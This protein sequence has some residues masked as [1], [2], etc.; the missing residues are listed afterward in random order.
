MSN[1]SKSLGKNPFLI[2]QSD[3]NSVTDTNLIGTDN[4]KKIF[5]TTRFSFS[6]VLLNYIEPEIING[7]EKTV[8]YSEINT[9]LEKGDKVFILNGNYDSD[10]YIDQNKYESN[11]DG[12]EVLDVDRCRIVLDIKYNGN[13]PY[14]ENSDD[15]IDVYYV[16]TIDELGSIVSTFSNDIVYYE[17]ELN[18]LFYD[19][20]SGLTYSSPTVS[21]FIELNGSNYSNINTDFD[22]GSGS[23]TNKKI[24]IINYNLLYNDKEYKRDFVYKYDSIKGWILSIENLIPIITK[25]NFRGGK[26]DGGSWNSGVYGRSDKVLEWTGLNNS[27]WGGGFLYNSD[28]KG[29]VLDSLDTNVSSFICRLKNGIPVQESIESNNNGYGY[30]YI[31]NSDIEKG[32]IN[33]GNIIKTNFT[34][35][36]GTNIVKEYIKEGTI[37]SNDIVVNG[38][39]FLNSDISDS[40]LSG[41]KLVNTKLKNSLLKNGISVNSQINSSVFNNSVYVTDEVINVLEISTKDYSN[42]IEYTFKISENSINRLRLGDS[43]YI[44]GIIDSIDN[45]VLS[46][47][48]KKFKLSNWIEKFEYINNINQVAIKEIR[49]TAFIEDLSIKII[50]EK[51]STIS[52][53]IIDT[54]DTKNIFI[55]D[56]NYESGLFE[57]SDWNSGFNINNGD[58]ISKSDGNGEY[59]LKIQNS[60][61]LKIQNS[62]VRVNKDEVIFLNSVEHVDSLERK[63]MLDDSYISIDEYGKLKEISSNV[64]SG[65]TSSTYTFKTGEGLNRNGYIH[66]LKFKDSKINSGIFKRTY[67]NN[68]LIQNKFYK[69]TDRDLLDIRNIRSLFINESIFYKTKNTLSSATYVNCLFEDK[70]DIVV[71]GIVHNSIWNGGIFNKGVFRESTWING[72]FNGGEFYKNNTF[73]GSPTN[74]K[75]LLTDNRIN[76]FYKSGPIPN[77]RYSWQNGKFN[78]GSFIKSDWENGDF[79]DGV[80]IESKFYGGNINGGVLGK[81]SLDYT[82]TRI[83]NG[84]INNT[85][86]ENAYLFT[87]DYEYTGLEPRN[88][89]WNNGVFEKGV[90][91]SRNIVRESYYTEVGYNNINRSENIDFIYTSNDNTI[92]RIDI[93]D[94]NSNQINIQQ[95]K[96]AETGTSIKIISDSYGNIFDIKSNKITKYSKNDG[97]FKLRNGTN[98]EINYTGSIVK[99]AL[100]DESDNLYVCLSNRIDK[101]DSNKKLIWSINNNSSNVSIGYDGEFIYIG[102]HITTSG[103]IEKWSK[104]GENKWRSTLGYI[105]YDSS[106]DVK[107]ISKIIEQNNFILISFIDVIYKID[108]NSGSILDSIKLSTISSLT[109]EG[110]AY[111]FQDYTYVHI[112]KRIK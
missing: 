45:S 74:E 16:S 80:F 96:G 50:F 69:S 27:K 77:N 20:K 67:F 53:P 92:Y 35:S 9:E 44:K 7:V 99:D 73:N 38:G 58:S 31:L 28:W 25:S 90:F 39:L 75:P 40:V 78:G 10:I 49:S 98:W 71:D 2:S 3:L 112:E 5:E 42:K 8:F 54:T 101:Y 108:K 79:N 102:G 46:F 34:N 23:F 103:Y 30:N 18:Q 55:L 37:P 72:E 29:G 111:S 61:E 1:L 100:V 107:Y 41:S 17:G 32:T 97:V 33:N 109:T 6:S 66:R 63:T 65:L 14:I 57:S 19:L 51:D 70:Q 24:K 68:C 106:I 26:I 82:K 89:L 85:R 4:F 21:G 56:S 11:S 22:N 64:L 47:F 81:K 86:V 83:Y 104:N 60:D 84:T 52:F 59:N 12:Y 93:D 48:H 13:K 105:Y 110:Y 91:G 62:L 76:S 88:I 87:E 95:T 36:L 94:Q 43:F 15:I